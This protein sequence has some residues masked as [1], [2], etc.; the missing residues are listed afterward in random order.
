MVVSY[1]IIDVTFDMLVYKF[2]DEWDLLW[3]WLHISNLTRQWL[4]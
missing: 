3:A 4:G 1:S 2:D